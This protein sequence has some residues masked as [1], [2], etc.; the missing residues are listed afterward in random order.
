MKN[1]LFLL[2]V[3]LFIITLTLTN[4]SDSSSGGSG[5]DFDPSQ[6]YTQTEVD[7]LID[8]VVANEDADGQNITA[9]DWAGRTATGWDAPDG[10]KGAIMELLITNASASDITT[11]IEVS[12][13]DTTGAAMGTSMTAPN[14]GVYYSKIFYVPVTG[15]ATIVAYHPYSSGHSGITDLSSLAGYTITVTP[16]AWFQ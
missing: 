12:A 11:Y 14:D 5:A 9:N 13:S 2:P 15:G 1:K 4:C 6:Y 7:A 8:G 3:F 10:A 16:V